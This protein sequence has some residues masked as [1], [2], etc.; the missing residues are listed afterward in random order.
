[1]IQPIVEI[2]KDLPKGY[3]VT[4]H[5]LL[6]AITSASV[7]AGTVT[8]DIF[9]EYRN[10]VGLMLGKNF[11]R[12]RVAAGYFYSAESDYWSHRL[13]LSLSRR[14][15]GDSATVALSVSRAFDTISSRSR[16]LEC[17]NPGEFHCTLDIYF[18]SASYT[19]ILSPRLL[20]QVSYDVSYLDGFQSSPYRVVAN[21]SWERVPNTRVRHVAV[22]RLAYYIPR[23]STGFQLHYRFYYDHGTEATEPG[24][25]WGIASHMAEGRVY[26]KLG[27][28]LELRL[29]YRQYFQTPANFWCDWMKDTACYQ[30]GARY[31]ATDPKLGGPIRTAMPEAKLTWDAVA[32]RGVPFFGWFAAGT[33]EISYGYLFQN[34]MF[35]NAHLLQTGYSMPY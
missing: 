31:Y 15:W 12:T 34:T 27:R 33:F 29:S 1:V 6:D 19:Q 32:L 17:A 13:G 23:S 8:D 25:P 18:G 9:T 10:E 30:P 35:G 21:L 24:N 11:D 2:S 28:D 7:A 3:D 20:A 14:M 16:T 4:T 5:Y 26:Q 22:G